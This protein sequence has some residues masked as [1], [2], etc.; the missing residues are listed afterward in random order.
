MKEPSNLDQLR[1]AALL[2]EKTLKT[3]TSDSEAVL[4]AVLS[5]INS[6]ETKQKVHQLMR[7]L[8]QMIHFQMPQLLLLTVVFNRV[9]SA[10]LTGTALNT[11]APILNGI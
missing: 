10:W 3:T 1:H 8:T 9:C 7:H 11:P 5:K 4:G 2:C 6:L